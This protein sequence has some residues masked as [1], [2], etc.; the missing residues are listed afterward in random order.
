MP[1]LHPVRRARDARQA[2]LALVV[3]TAVAACGSS[4]STGPTSNALVG[5]YQLQAVNG[6]P[7]PYTKSNGDQL[8]SGGVLVHSDATYDAG[9]QSTGS[10]GSA[11]VD[12]VGSNW[13]G[14]GNT[15]QFSNWFGGGTAQVALQGSVLTVTASNL[16]KTYQKQ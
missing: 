3:A 2:A 8:V 13:S 14:S 7:L 11:K 16:T 5:T 1:F 12:S 4:D 9:E 6:S 15:G 10:D